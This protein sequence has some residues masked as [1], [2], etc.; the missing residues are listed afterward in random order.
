MGVAYEWEMEGEI[1]PHHPAVSFQR[2][3]RSTVAHSYA[4]HRDARFVLVEGFGGAAEGGG[5]GGVGGRI[6]LGSGSRNAETIDHQRINGGGGGV[7]GA[8]SLGIDVGWN[9]FAWKIGKVSPNLEPY[10]ASVE[11]L[12]SPRAVGM[13]ATAYISPGAELDMALG[14][15]GN[16]GGGGGGYHHTSSPRSAADANEMKYMHHH[17]HHHHHQSAA[18]A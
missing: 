5:G 17:H 7:G 9:P 8:G 3:Q 18:A 1:Y 15:G 13:A 2:K 10:P 14:G 11:G 4:H 12:N 16:G 6:V